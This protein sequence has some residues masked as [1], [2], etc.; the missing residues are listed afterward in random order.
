[1]AKL[2]LRSIRVFATKN[3]IHKTAKTSICESMKPSTKGTYQTEQAKIVAY[4]SPT[5]LAPCVDLSCFKSSRKLSSKTS[6]NERLKFRA[7][8][9]AQIWNVASKNPD[10]RDWFLHCFHHCCLRLWKLQFFCSDRSS[11]EHSRSIHVR[12]IDITALVLAE[13]MVQPEAASIG[14]KGATWK[15][16]DHGLYWEVLCD[17]T[18]AIY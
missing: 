17:H 3:Q 13:I 10:R 4:G 15:R 8:D 5:H 2:A 6:R 11:I 12:S 16:G 14:Q 7:L 1:M 9:L 18:T